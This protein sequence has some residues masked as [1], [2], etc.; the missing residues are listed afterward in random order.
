M[1]TA[2]QDTPTTEEIA[3]SRGLFASGMRLVIA[4]IKLHPK[5]FFASL[6]GAILFAV[7]ST[8][9]DDG[10]RPR[11]ERRARAGV[12]RHRGRRQHGLV[13]GRAR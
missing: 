9:A 10:D 1:A 12:R 13:G 8:G 7:S 2:L 3:S 4:Y 11:D 5:P 6:A